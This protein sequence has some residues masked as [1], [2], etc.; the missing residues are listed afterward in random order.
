MMHKI[1][2]TFLLLISL[3]S[4]ATAEEYSSEK[5]LPTDQ[6]GYVNFVQA[7]ES[8]KPVI[9]K[10]GLEIC[11]GCIE[12]NQL[13]ISLMSSYRGSIYFSTID[14][15]ENREAETTYH[16][17]VMPT[18]IFFDPSGKEIHRIEG[19]VTKEAVVKQL[20]KMIRSNQNE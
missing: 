3:T 9:A 16:L 2:I 7:L 4:C 12:A 14:L 20:D 18:I 8:G 15:M 17:T 19:L 6:N 13:L 10:F 11:T 5:Y 1:L